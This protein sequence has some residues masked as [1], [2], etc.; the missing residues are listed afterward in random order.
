MKKSLKISEVARL[1]GVC[2]NTVRNYEAKGFLLTVKDKCGHRCFDAECVL[3]FLKRKREMEA[4]D[5]CI[6]RLE[7]LCE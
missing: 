6:R 7:A 5:D 4:I 3:D 2:E 1:L